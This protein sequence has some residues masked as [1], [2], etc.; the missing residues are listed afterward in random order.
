M[1]W[2]LGVS[3]IDAVIETCGQAGLAFEVATEHPAPD[4]SYRIVTVR[5]PNGMDVILEEQ[6]SG[7]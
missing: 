4:W 2:Q 6:R 1:T 3:D 5:S 7:R